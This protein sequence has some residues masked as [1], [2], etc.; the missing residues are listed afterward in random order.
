MAISLTG[1]N[2]D[3]FTASQ[4]QEIGQRAEYMEMGDGSRGM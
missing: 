4:G 3:G 1:C 2:A